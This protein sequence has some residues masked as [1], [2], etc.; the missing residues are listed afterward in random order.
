MGD[1]GTDVDERLRSADAFLD[2][3]RRIEKLLT[4]RYGLANVHGL[5]QI[6]DQVASKDRT[7]RHNRRAL[8]AFTNLRNTLAHEPYQ[9]GLPI[10]SPLPETVTEVQRVADEIASPRPIDGVMYSRDVAVADRADPIRGHLQRLLECDFSQLPVL[11]VRSD[12][13]GADD[14]RRS[15]LGG[16]SYG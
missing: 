8:N 10:A 7:V 14:Q 15:T 12:R 4:D 9:N 13:D 5:G 3:C 2:A 11:G 16:R 1:S 6:V